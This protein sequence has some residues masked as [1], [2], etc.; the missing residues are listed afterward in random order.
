MRLLL[1]S[2]AFDP[3]S[4]VASAGCLGLSV[5]RVSWVARQQPP[6]SNQPR[7]QPLW[8]PFSSMPSSSSQVTS[9]QKSVISALQLLARVPLRG[10]VLPTVPFFLHSWQTSFAWEKEL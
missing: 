1:R 2:Y 6:F 4:F 10:S 8:S 5:L 3:S 9:S 7:L